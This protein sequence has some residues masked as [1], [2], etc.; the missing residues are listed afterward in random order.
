MGVFLLSGSSLPITYLSVYGF[1]SLLLLLPPLF[2]DISD[3][4]DDLSDIVEEAV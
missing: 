1:Q 2:T 4:E 3:F